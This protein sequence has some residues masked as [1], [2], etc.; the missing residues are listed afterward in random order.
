[1]P[2]KAARKADRNATLVLVLGKPPSLAWEA[3]RLGMGWPGKSTV[4]PG[5]E[6]AAKARVASFMAPAESPVEGGR[7]ST[8]PRVAL[9]PPPCPPSSEVERRVVRGVVVL[10]MSQVA[11][12]VQAECIGEVEP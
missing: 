1:M 9:S 12:R 2:C 10:G 5:R 4:N 8:A 6:Q 7:A 3:E 11:G